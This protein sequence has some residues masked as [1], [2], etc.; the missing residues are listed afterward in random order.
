M[1][2]YCLAPPTNLIS[3]EV[4]A[5]KHNTIV[6]TPPADDGSLETVVLKVRLSTMKDLKIS[7]RPT[8]LVRDIKS[9]LHQME[10]ISPQNVKLLY[11]GRLL[12][13]DQSLNDLDIPK[14][15]VIQ[16]VITT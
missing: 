9:K 15:Y 7:V 14:G 2:K 5:H 1:P 8:A 10:G 3:Q 4:T 13:D 12:K 16:A 11:S 6:D